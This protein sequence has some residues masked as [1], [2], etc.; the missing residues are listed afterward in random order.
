MLAW[1]VIYRL[2][3]RQAR[4]PTAIRLFRPPRPLLR[5][6]FCIPDGFAG[7]S[8]VQT[9]RRSGVSSHVFACPPIAYRRSVTLL[10][11]TLEKVSHK[12]SLTTFRMN[13]CKSVSKQR[14]LTTFGMN[15]YE[16]QGEGVSVIVNQVSEE[17]SRPERAQRDG[18]ERATTR[19]LHGQ[20]LRA[21]L[22]FWA[23]LRGGR[24]RLRA[25]W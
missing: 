14:T 11:S 2:H 17:D 7:R 16:K 19:V 3:L 9:L 5:C 12:P 10:E 8:D 13:T 18:A 20:L 24:G 6:A 15:T 1:V 22:C 4:K 23:C 21:R 25:F